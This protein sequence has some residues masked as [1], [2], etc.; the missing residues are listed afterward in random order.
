M[1]ESSYVHHSHFDD[2]DKELSRNLDMSIT[3]HISMILIRKK[4]KESSYVYHC[5][6]FDGFDKDL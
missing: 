3:M 2:F 5:L 4:V 1:K 6:Y